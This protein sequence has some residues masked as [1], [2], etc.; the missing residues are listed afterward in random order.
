MKLF[1]LTQTV[2]IS[3]T[4]ADEGVNAEISYSLQGEACAANLTSKVINQF[5]N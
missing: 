2:T 1:L 4:D 3:A 5:V